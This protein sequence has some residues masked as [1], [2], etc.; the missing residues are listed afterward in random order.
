MK[1]SIQVSS[2]AAAIA[3]SAA[4][5]APATAI[6]G[7]SATVGVSN[8][9]LY[10]G[11]DLSNPNAQVSGSLDY[12]HASG[13]YAGVWVSNSG[14]STSGEYDAYVG[15]STAVAGLSVDVNLTSYEYPQA[16]GNQKYGSLSEFI[17]NLG[18]DIPNAGKASFGAAASLQGDYVY[19]S[20]GYGMGKVSGTLGLQQNSDAAANDYTHLDLS[21]ALNDE[22]AVTV[23]QVIDQDAARA[24]AGFIDKDPK[25]NLAWSKKFD[26]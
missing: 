20:L 3:L 15:Y 7:V 16:A 25:I 17:L 5:L 10:R 4:A 12:N 13:A 22:V 2:L 18:Y 14:T 24:D 6:A 23:S 21:Y 26:L 19:Y 8:F 1:R 9:Y 11:L